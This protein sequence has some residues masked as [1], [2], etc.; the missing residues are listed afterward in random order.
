[1]SKFTLFTGKDGQFYW[2]L[3]AGNGEIIGQSE[4]YTSKAAATNGIDSTRKHATDAHRYE[5]KDS[6]NGKYYWHLKAA[7]GQIIMSS[8]MYETKASAEKGMQSA[9]KNAPEATLTDDTESTKAA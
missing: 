5:L 9:M 4:G 1:M 8:Q 6:K 3:K 2:N 7:N